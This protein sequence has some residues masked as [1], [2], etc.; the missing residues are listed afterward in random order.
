MTIHTRYSLFMI[1]CV[2]SL[3]ASPEVTYN[4]GLHFRSFEVDQDKRTG[5]N[6]TPDSKILTPGGLRLLS[7][8]NCSDNPII[9]AM[10]SDC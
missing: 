9:L 2:I 6:L 8:F 1:L 7:I 3:S 4:R 5:L 10:C